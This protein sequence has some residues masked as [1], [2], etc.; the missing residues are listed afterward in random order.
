MN[1]FAYGSLIIPEVWEAVTGELHRSEP[2]RISGFIRRT[3]RGATYPGIIAC[4]PSGG[5]LEVDG[6]IYYDVGAEALDAL[7]EFESDFYV[8]SA[9]DAIATDGGGGPITCQAY[10]VPAANAHLLSDSEWDLERFAAEHLEEFI[11]RNFG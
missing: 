2:G 5:D 1:L 11:A 8:R 6:A 3:I 7:D 4:K 10:L 9:V